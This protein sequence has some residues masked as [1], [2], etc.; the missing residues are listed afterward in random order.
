MS[1][2]LIAT[3]MGMLLFAMG[4]FAQNDDAPYMINVDFTHFGQDGGKMQMSLPL[5]FIE[6]IKP[7]IEEA[8]AEVQHGDHGIDVAA[9][10]KAIKEAGPTNFVEIDSKDGK[11]TV[12]T[13]ETYFLVHV[14]NEEINDLNV[15]IPLELCEAL[16][17]GGGD[18][19]Y[20][21]VVESLKG[22]VGKELINIDSPEIKGRIWLTR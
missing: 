15:K 22:M 19:D 18:I 6:S 12:K 20:D 16:L 2:K 4:A 9:L 21:R 3:T 13:D 8:L 7:K 10:W 1:K 11:V 5:D 14:E 17:A